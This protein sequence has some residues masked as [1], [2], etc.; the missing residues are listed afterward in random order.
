MWFYDAVV[1]QAAAAVWQQQPAA[2]DSTVLVLQGSMQQADRQLVDAT[3]VDI[4]EPTT[5]TH[6]LA[7]RL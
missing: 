5:R 7:L 3:L 2:A 1:G 4:W 6:C